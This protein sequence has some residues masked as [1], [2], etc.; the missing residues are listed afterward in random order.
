MTIRTRL[1]ISA[2]VSIVLVIGL[3]L[4]FIQVSRQANEAAEKGQIVDDII[5]GVL[6]LNLL[7]FDYTLRPAERAQQ[8]WL[9]K[10]N[11]IA[12]LLASEQFNRPDESVILDE[13]RQHH[14]NAGVLFSRPSRVR[15]RRVHWALA[16]C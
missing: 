8:Q 15:P 1:L 11:T 9:I 6:E 13:M 2:I 12:Q 10:H 14:A 7:T 3:G 16:A 4:I 5:E